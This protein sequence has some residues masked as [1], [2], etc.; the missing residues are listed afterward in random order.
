[1][2]EKEKLRDLSSPVQDRDDVD[3][4]WRSP[5]DAGERS[6]IREGRD[7]VKKKESRG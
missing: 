5:R 2:G 1:L 6:M 7:L 3:F 4:Y